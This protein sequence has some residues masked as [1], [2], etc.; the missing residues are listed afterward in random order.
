MNLELHIH[1]KFSHDSVMGFLCLYMKCRM[2]KID[3]IA[4]TEHNNICGA[5]R[6]KEF[7][8][9]H[10]GKVK[11]IVGEEIMT[12]SGE[13]IGLYLREQISPGLSVKETIELIKKQDGIVYVPH[14]Y[15]EKRRKTVLL[16]REIELNKKNIDCI[17]CHNG[18][19]ISKQYDAKQTEI[20]DRYNIT[21]VIGSDAH[22]VLEIGRNYMKISTEPNDAQAFKNA[23][24]SAELH[25]KNCI[26]FCH[27][28]T[29]AARLIKLIGQGEWD[30]LRRVVYKKVKR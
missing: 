9:R 29:K 21:K 26:K 28:I 24:I 25:T 16:E 22:T 18:R 2:C 3:W 1:T 17:E 7:C 12:E 19:N 11:V 14:P 10:G 15:D 6:F 23:I 30:E 13:I 4:V 20:A 5:L 8:E 27:T